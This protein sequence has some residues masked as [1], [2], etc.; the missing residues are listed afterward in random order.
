MMPKS[1]AAR[2]RIRAEATIALA[3]I[4]GPAVSVLAAPDMRGA[5][6]AALALLML[7]IAVIDAGHMII[8]DR[9]NATGFAL[10]LVNAGAVDPQ[11][12]LPAAAIAV[13]R[14]GLLA[15]LFLALRVGYR[16]L[17]GRHGLGL[18][19]VKLAGVAGAW[20]DWPTIPAVV[21]MAALMAL[22]AYTVRQYLL[23]RP[24]HPTGRLPFG[25]FFAPAIWLGWL[26]ETLALVRF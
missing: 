7:A 17:R 22:A 25:L 21:E 18:G 6:G 20:L 24:L 10:A 1:L 14:G 9:L 4:A 5:L 11:N 13:L 15:L 12:A 16:R 26:L 23:G 3:A 19:D 8:P 2:P